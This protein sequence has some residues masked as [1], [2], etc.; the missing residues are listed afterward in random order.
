M[1]VRIIIKT[2]KN[3]QI[4]NLSKEEFYILREAVGG[5]PYETLK[6]ENITA[7]EVHQVYKKL[8]NIKIN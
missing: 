8:E 5:C 1:S 7:A 2:D 3:T 6:E 4:L